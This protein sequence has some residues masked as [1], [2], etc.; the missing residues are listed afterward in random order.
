MDRLTEVKEELLSVLSGR[1]MHLLDTVLPA[2]IFLFLTPLLGILPSLAVSLGTAVVIFL[3]RVIRKGNQY[4]ALG[5]LGAAA[6]A[7]VFALISNSAVGF[8]L[9]SLI[10]SGL[11]VLFL[12]VSVVIRRP[13][14]A[15]TSHLTRGWPL[16]W[17]WHE[18]ILP[19]YVEVTLLWTLSFGARLGLEYWLYLKAEV[20]SLGLVQTILGWPF[21]ILILVVSYLYGVW[22]LQQLG[23]PSV[24]E[25]SAE[26]PPPW[27]G[28][29]RGF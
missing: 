13:L 14:A 11:T 22:R 10:T 19:A 15:L 9:P 5:G 20:G 26:A 12:A 27:Q 3:V 17:Y 1:G 28:Q 8:F 25:F 16:A 24:E 18:R 29:Q 23:G 6:L 4:Y 7:G 2:L 21:T